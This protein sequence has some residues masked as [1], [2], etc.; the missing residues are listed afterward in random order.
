MGRK[1]DSEQEI[2]RLMVLP[3]RIEMIPDDDGWFISIPDLPGC[4]SQGSTIE[5]A[6][7]MIR[8]AQHMWLQTALEDGIAIPEPGSAD[9]REYSGKFNVR[10]SRSLHRD[11]V[12]AATLEGVSL[13]LYVATALARAV[14]PASTQKV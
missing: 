10:V 13:N 3:Y 8:D 14:P 9:Q 1:I 7:E 5:E 11:L 4:I 6:L 2:K 12:R